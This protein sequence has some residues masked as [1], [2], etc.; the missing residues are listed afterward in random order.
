MKKPFLW[1]KDRRIDKRVI[2]DDAAERNCGRRIRA[3]R[4]ESIAGGNPVK[5]TE[6]F[7]LS[8]LAL[9]LGLPR[10][11]TLAAPIIVGLRGKIALGFPRREKRSS[12]DSARW[13]RA[14]KKRSMVRKHFIALSNLSMVFSNVAAG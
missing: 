10:H 4:V 6:M 2:G 14:M 3:S 11:S 12:R 7:F 1:G 8:A 13:G 9:G 5:L